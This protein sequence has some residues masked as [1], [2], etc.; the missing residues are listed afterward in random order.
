MGK[1]PANLDEKLEQLLLLKNF[2][3]LQSEEKQ[4][5]L[6]QIGE[7]EYQE[8]RIILIES[9]ELFEKEKDIIQPDPQIKKDLLIAFDKR[10]NSLY[11]IQELVKNSI[12]YKVPAYQSALALAAILLIFFFLS[13]GNEIEPI[14]TPQTVYV[15]KTDT[16]FVLPETKMPETIPVNAIANSENKQS[17]KPKKKIINKP[18][19]P[20][21]KKTIKKK[22]EQTTPIKA[23][24]GIK[25]F[26]AFNSYEFLTE[27]TIGR[28]MKEDSVL[29]KFLVTAY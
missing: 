11:P 9:V 17:E 25:T 12:N 24:E 21:P 7:K 1:I 20:T 27:K 5:V 26:F 19:K 8:F 15:Y 22:E 28:T 29:T 4:Y 16:I 3:E 18:L 2:E 10:H 14:T 13:S 6:Q 23:P